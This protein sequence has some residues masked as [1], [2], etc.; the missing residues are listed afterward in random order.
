MTETIIAPVTVE[1]LEEFTPENISRMYFIIKAIYA[2]HP[3]SSE[4]SLGEFLNSGNVQVAIARKRGE[5]VG[6]GLLE[7]EDNPIYSSIT[8]VAALPEYRGGVGKSI[9][10]KLLEMSL[11]GGRTIIQTDPVLNHN[12]F[13][14]Q[15]NHPDYQ[16]NLAN[17]VIST[18]MGAVTTGFDIM[19]YISLTEDDM[20]SRPATVSRMVI[21]SN[22]CEG[23]DSE[24][25]SAKQKLLNYL[26]EGVILP[27]QYTTS[28]K[29][30]IEQ[31]DRGD[32]YGSVEIARAENIE[33]FRGTSFIPCYFLPKYCA[34]GETC[35]FGIYYSSVPIQKPE[36]GNDILMH[37]INIDGIR[38][39]SN[40]LNG[41]DIEL[42]RFL[43]SNIYQNY[44][45]N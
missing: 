36:N 31:K 12:T 21:N 17:L 14:M 5:I 22:N 41:D 27:N 23:V 37:G 4:E 3:I 24:L 33:D 6:L 13:D 35:Y 10:N 34:N 43:I 38:G 11:Q 20:Y 19:R 8:G 15:V 44:Y 45:Q 30:K 29:L 25:K 2:Q 40:I 7:L 18:K 1:R 9:N 42:L 32:K 28:K 16:P 39:M 26:K